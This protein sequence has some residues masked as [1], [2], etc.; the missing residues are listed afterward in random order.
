M[1][2]IIVVFVFILCFISLIGYIIFKLEELAQRKTEVLP[3]GFIEWLE[4]QPNKYEILEE[5]FK[6]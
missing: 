6:N 2:D 3:S 4:K 1:I 5:I